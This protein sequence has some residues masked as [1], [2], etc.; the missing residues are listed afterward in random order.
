MVANNGGYFSN[1]AFVWE[2]KG[3]SPFAIYVF[4]PG[5]KDVGSLFGYKDG[6]FYR[7]EVLN[8][9]SN[10]PQVL[11]WQV[12]ATD[13][14]V[15]GNEYVLSNT[16]VLHR[17]LP[18]RP[19]TKSG[20]YSNGYY[21][22]RFNGI[23]QENSYYTFQG[24]GGSFRTQTVALQ[25]LTLGA[26]YPRPVLNGRY[27]S[28]FSYGT[29]VNNTALQTTY[30]GVVTFSNTNF[31]IDY[32]GHILLYRHSGSSRRFAYIPQDTSS[33]PE[34][35]AGTYKIIDAARGMIKLN[36]TPAQR[37]QLAFSGET[38]DPDTVDFTIISA[39]Q[40]QE[41]VSSGMTLY[42][43]RYG[44][45][46]DG[47][48][49]N[50]LL[51]SYV[52]DGQAHIVNEVPQGELSTDTGAV[53]LADSAS[54]YG[55]SVMLAV[56]YGGVVNA[57]EMIR[58]QANRYIP[59]VFQL[60]YSTGIL[61]SEAS[62]SP[63]SPDVRAV[64]EHNPTSWY[65]RDILDGSY[66]PVARS[67]NTWYSLMSTAEASQFDAF[68]PN[69]EFKIVDTVTLTSLGDVP[70]VLNNGD[71]LV[72]NS[73]T[74]A[75]DGV[76]FRLSNLRDVNIPPSPGNNQV[77]AYNTA[78]SRWVNTTA[79]AALG[80]TPV[81]K[82]GDTNISAKLDY[83]PAVSGF[84]ANSLITKGYVDTAISGITGGATGNLADHINTTTVPIHG[85]AVEPT[86]NR[87]VH[88]DAAGNARVMTSSWQLNTSLS[89]AQA[90]EV[91]NN[92]WINNRSRI[93]TTANSLVLRDANGRAQVYPPSTS[94]PSD[95]IA[96]KNYAEQMRPGIVV[97]AGIELSAQVYPAQTVLANY[98]FY[99]PNPYAY[100]FLVGDLS[101]DPPVT[102]NTLSPTYGINSD[103]AF[104]SNVVA[105]PWY[106][107]WAS[108]T[109]RNLR[110]SFTISG[111]K[112]ITTTNVPSGITTTGIE[113]TIQVLRTTTVSLV[114]G[115]RPRLY[116]YAVYY[117]GF[118]T[119]VGGGNTINSSDWIR[120]SW[121]L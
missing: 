40:L 94:S 11:E 60:Y 20:T 16:D 63:L 90:Y 99:V 112:Q 65:N 78:T 109:Y 53:L 86:A 61:T 82:A 93:Y 38:I 55:D 114:G 31:G 54:K 42:S 81:N 91:V 98:V 48:S 92:T 3:T 84:N 49:A 14:A 106:G 87:L 9:I 41:S 18:Y 107:N 43:S 116:V 108:S 56:T 5:L 79:N 101:T 4:T 33:S 96:T 71:V 23:P 29:G 44:D 13:A 77:L 64:V 21:D 36:I 120:S 6:E 51:L 45:V 70:N 2:T 111:F 8:A 30:G 47:E 97:I 7:F 115:S 121:S 103:T 69:Y 50:V 85:S 104:V 26:E 52:F 39:E 15:V 75:F 83:A 88:R 119:G 95:T 17:Q 102:S 22:I 113:F 100:N 110:N 59:D 105:V 58:V 24:S 57:V 25:G 35:T 80:Y 68:N 19:I 27:D 12:L 10:E 76:N 66:F 28:N 1:D 74:N 73:S 34:P 117:P 62:G 37:L 72:Y 67:V 46:Y 32:G 89:A 118:W